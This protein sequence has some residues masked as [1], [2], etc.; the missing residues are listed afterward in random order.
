MRKRQTGLG[1][2]HFVTNRDMQK[3]ISG[4]LRLSM[5]WCLSPDQGNVVF[6]DMSTS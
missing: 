1:M 6:I 4:M 5:G 2:R 3:F